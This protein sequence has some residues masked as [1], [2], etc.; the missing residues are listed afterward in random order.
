MRAWPSPGAALGPIDEDWVVLDEGVIVGRVYEN[1][2]T[3]KT[4]PPR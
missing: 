2:A 3:P 4:P 1:E